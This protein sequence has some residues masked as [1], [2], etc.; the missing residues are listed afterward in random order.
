MRRLLICCAIL[1][2]QPALADPS[3]KVNPRSPGKQGIDKIV[4]A[5]NSS[6][7]QTWLVQLDNFR[8][9]LRPTQQRQYDALVEQLGN[10]SRIQFDYRAGAQ[11]DPALQG[12]ALRGIAAANFNH[13][14]LLQYV[15]AQSVKEDGKLNIFIY[16]KEIPWRDFYDGMDG[17]LQGA[18]A[19]PKNDIAVDQVDFYG[20]LESGDNA[21]IHEFAHLQ[22]RVN[23]D[24]SQGM[25]RLPGD[26]PY[27]AQ[28]A[29]EFSHPQMQKFLIGYFLG[30]TPPKEEE[31]LGNAESWPTV[32]NLFHQDPEALKSASPRIYQQLRSYFGIDPLTGQPSQP[33]RLKAS[34]SP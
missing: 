22:Q 30:G 2:A 17:S 5:V 24:G 29:R 9:R 16:P 33:V 15:I 31:A 26:F 23:L 18:L 19:T 7:D 1:L 3:G 8:S 12:L 34:V 27:A 11:N 32:Q 25:A 28:F 4:R 14:Q 20:F 13:P 6:G 21:F 10:D